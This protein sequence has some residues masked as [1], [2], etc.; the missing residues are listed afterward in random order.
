VRA[1]PDLSKRINVICPVQPHLQKYF[2]S[3]LTQIKSISIAIPSH[4]EGRIMIVTNA[5]WDAVAAA[6]PARK[7]DRRA[8]CRERLPGAQTNG[9]EADGEVVWS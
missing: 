7:S 3:R 1:Q 6:V 9:A 4:T 2:P 5:G 8:V